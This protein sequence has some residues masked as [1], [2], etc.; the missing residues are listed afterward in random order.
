MTT[1][2]NQAKFD[3][4]GPEPIEYR[5]ISAREGATSS[6]ST[7]PEPAARQG[8]YY[9]RKARNEAV[10][11]VKYD[12]KQERERLVRERIYELLAQ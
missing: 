6:P 11:V 7:A 10:A 2:S 1:D 4:T 9:S 8:I 5:T 12:A 3:T